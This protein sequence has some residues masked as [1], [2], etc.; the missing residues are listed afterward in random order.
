MASA[1]VCGFVPSLLLPDS[2][3]FASFNGESLVITFLGAFILLLIIRLFVGAGAP[4]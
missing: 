2:F 4:S 1:P 3:V